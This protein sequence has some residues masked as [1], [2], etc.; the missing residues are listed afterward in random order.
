MRGNWTE[1][2]LK[3]VLDNAGLVEGQDYELPH[4]DPSK[5]SEL[6]ADAVIR[7]DGGRPLPA[8]K[9]GTSAFVQTGGRIDPGEQPAAALAR[10]MDLAPLAA[11]IMLPRYG[12]QP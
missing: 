7:D 8:R 4:A 2:T 9:G 12:R 11:A 1:L 5:P 6:I 3:T 10:G